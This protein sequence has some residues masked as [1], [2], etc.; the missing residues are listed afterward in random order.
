MREKETRGEERD[1]GRKEKERWREREQ[2]LRAEFLLAN[3]KT[4]F[5]SSFLL[6]FPSQQGAA[7]KNITSHWADPSAF[8][9]TRTVPEEGQWPTPGEGVALRRNASTWVLEETSILTTIMPHTKANKTVPYVQSPQGQCWET[10]VGQ[11]FASAPREVPLTPH[12]TTFGGITV[13]FS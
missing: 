8:Y 2:S 3:V 5:I 10:Y 11:V 4:S 12:L 7:T 6:S 13:P 1:G 9:A